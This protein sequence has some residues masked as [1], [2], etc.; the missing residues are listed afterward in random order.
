MKVITYSLKDTQKNSDRY[1]QQIADFTD[2]FLAQAES[3][4]RPL[5]DRYIDFIAT[6]QIEIP[7]SFDEYA[8]ELL[9]VGVL[10][11][12]YAPDAVKINWTSR[13]ILTGLVRARRKSALLKPGIDVLRGWLGQA[14]LPVSFHRREKDVHPQFTLPN[15]RKLT[16]WLEAAGDFREET[17]RIRQWLEYFSALPPIALEKDLAGV[18]DLAAWFETHSLQALGMYTARVDDFLAEDWPHYKF[19]ED[20][21]FCGRRRVEYHLN[22]VGTEILNRAFR[23]AFMA[24]EHKIIFVPPCMAAPQDGTCQAVDTPLG[25]K[26]QACTPTCRVHHVTKLG[27]KY[28]AQVFMI[29][30]SFSPLANGADGALGNRTIGVVGVS[31]PLAIISGGLETQRMGVPAQGLLLDYCGCQW[32]WDVGKGIVTDINMHQLTQIM[33]DQLV[34]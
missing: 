2:E 25:A 32:H 17:A 8:F 3:L 22:M 23:P 26:C 6:H 21:V 16:G 1:Y 9:L 29:P 31:C 28:G 10:W 30:D 20:R 14:A 27:E 12:E 24:A 15:L 5:V 19:R 18:L 13:N 34:G 7:R 33:T 4:V 11:R